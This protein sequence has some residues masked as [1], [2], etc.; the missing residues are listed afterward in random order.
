MLVPQPV[1]MREDGSHRLTD[2][3]INM[4]GLG[5][6]MVLNQRCFYI[7]NH[8]RDGRIPGRYGVTEVGCH[9]SSSPFPALKRA[10]YPFPAG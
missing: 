9:S 6:R 7:K 8:K 1:V 5:G 3:I 2:L 10:G 4:T